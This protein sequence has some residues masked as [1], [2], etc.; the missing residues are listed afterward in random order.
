MTAR[1]SSPTAVRLLVLDVDGVMTDGRIWMDEAGNNV[2]G[3]CTQDGTAIRMWQRA[4]HQAA[5]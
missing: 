5:W 3:F 1:F 4:G 2:R